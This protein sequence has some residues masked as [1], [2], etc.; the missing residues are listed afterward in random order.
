M[1]SD[2]RAENLKT[3]EASMSSA[4]KRGARLLDTLGQ[5]KLTQ[6]LRSHLVREVTSR[7]DLSRRFAIDE[8]LEHYSL[9]EV[10]A[11][12]RVV[13]ERLSRKTM[14]QVK[15]HLGL[16][17]MRRF[18]EA[19]YPLI[20]PQMLR[21]RAEGHP[22]DLGV[23]KAGLY[24][25]YVGLVEVTRLLIG[26]DIDTF[27][28]FLDDGVWTD[29]KGEEWGLNDTLRAL[30]SPDALARMLRRPEEKWGP[31]EYALAGLRKFLVFC[32]E[33]DNLLQ[34]HDKYPLA[35]SAMW[36][37]QGYWFEQVGGQV[38][39][40]IAT[41]LERYREFAEPGSASRRATRAAVAT[42]LQLDRSLLGLRR[43]TSGVYRAPLEEV[44][45]QDVWADQRSASL[46]RQR[47]GRRRGVSS[48]GA[49]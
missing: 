37:F 3:I 10:A 9:L 39:G 45:Y 28:S 11:G 32:Q 18:Y 34:A 36:H 7:S 26:D 41:A 43:L 24:Q 5:E 22:I 1:G 31:N 38:G 44:V 35:Q 15:A 13:P 21:M 49:R 14:V 19:Y 12:L 29:S 2:L 4:A 46:R 47:L 30:H 25:A 48:K 23:P 27:L 16:P 17:T 20:L 33:F 8:L 40:V 6:L 42:H